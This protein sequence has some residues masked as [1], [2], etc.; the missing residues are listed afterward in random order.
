MSEE[1]T[2]RKYTYRRIASPVSQEEKDALKGIEHAFASTPNTPSE[3]K[4]PAIQRRSE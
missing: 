4:R 1:S 2:E 3:L